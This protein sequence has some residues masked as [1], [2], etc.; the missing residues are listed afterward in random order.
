[1]ATQPSDAGG[2]DDDWER[3][4]WASGDYAR[5]AKQYL[6]MAARVV[7]AVGL[8]AGDRVLDVGTG[9]GNLA[10]TA[11]KTGADV[12]GI[13][14]CPDLLE[15]ARERTGTLG[16]EEITFETGD[17]ADLPYADDSFDVTVS[18]LGHMYADPP[19]AAANELLRVT[20]PGGRIA[21]T[22]WTPMSLYPRMAGVALQHVPP[23]ALP[24]YTEPPFM[25]GDEAT[26]RD[27]LADDLAELTTKT[28]VC[29][30]PAVSPR[31]FW[32]ETKAT[33]GMFQLLVS[34]VDAT[35][36]QELDAAMVETIDSMFDPTEN[37]VTLQY[38][39]VIGI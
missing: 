32:E 2:F 39:T 8:E 22:A 30:Y 36:R 10:L 35:T 38:L 12:T 25:W 11:S 6:P 17:A 28:R 14:I 1:M 4:V 21:F 18:N 3:D 29:T 9:T 33:S 15:T 26:V 37:E 20:R 7:D 5:T 24:D 19:M 23:S 34:S 13:D 27:R 16:I 31:A